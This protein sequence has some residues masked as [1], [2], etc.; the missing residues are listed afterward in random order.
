MESK[1]TDTRGRVIEIVHQDQRH[2]DIEVLLEKKAIEFT[3]LCH[4]SV[5]LVS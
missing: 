2:P 1:K 5:Q 4:T 3:R